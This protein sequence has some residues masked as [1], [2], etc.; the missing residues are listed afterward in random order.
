MTDT[1]FDLQRFAVTNAVL[2]GGQSSFTWQDGETFGAGA[3]TAVGTSSNPA[4]LDAKGGFS[5]AGTSTAV[6]LSGEKNYSF[7]LDGKADW[8]LKLGNDGVAQ[9]TSSDGTL[10]LGDLDD[11]AAVLN[12]NGTFEETVS[13]NSAYIKTAA[14]TKVTLNTRSNGLV[15]QFGKDVS[16]IDVVVYDNALGKSATAEFAKGAS[17]ID[18]GVSKDDLAQGFGF[19]K[20]VTVG[21]NVLNEIV[22]S[23]DKNNTVTVAGGDV[24]KVKKGE[25]TPTIFYSTVNKAVDVVNNIKGATLESA[26]GVTSPVAVA[27]V[28]WNSIT[29]GV[30]SIAFDSVGAA[31]VDNT[32]AITVQGQDGAVATVKNL[33][34]ATV[35]GIKVT[36]AE[37]GSVGFTLETLTGGGVSAIDVSKALGT[38]ITVAKD[39]AFNVTAG[40]SEY[41]IATDANSVTFNATASEVQ[42]N[43]AKEQAYTVSGNA[44][45]I[46]AEDAKNVSING[47][48]ISLGTAEGVVAGSDDDHEGITSITGLA[49]G[50]AVSVANDSD[51][52]TATFN[53]VEGADAVTFEVNGTS[54][55]AAGIDGQQVNIAV[56]GTGKEVTITGMGTT[57]SVT[58]SGGDGI[59][60]HFKDA[61]SSNRVAPSSGDSIY[62][63]LSN[64]AVIDAMD[65]DTYK[66]LME[67]DKGKWDNAA[68]IGNQTESNPPVDTVVSNLS[69]VFAQFY[70][71]N[72][73][74][75]GQA[76]MAGFVNEN[77]TTF[78]TSSVSGGVNFSGR[79][80]S[81][82]SAEGHVTLS[83]G[84]NVSRATP[85]NIQQNESDV[86]V[87]VVVDL[88]NETVPAT[89]A[90]GTL[91]DNVS[92][93]V[94]ASHKIYLSNAGGFAY[95]GDLATGQ[96]QVFAGTTGAQIRHD[97]STRATI[98][99]G[100]G[101]DTIWAGKNDIVAG[102]LG[103]DQFYD[104]ADYTITDY[105]FAQGD[106]LIATRFNSVSDITRDNIVSSGNTVSFGES[107][108]SFTLGNDQNASLAM[109]VAVMD[110]EAN[111]VGSRAVILAGANGGSVDASAITSGALIIADEN[112]NGKS[113]DAIVGTAGNDDI[114]VS[115]NDLVD[116][117]AGNDY[118]TIS[119]VSAAE[120][121]GGAKV[122]LG[123]GKDTVAGW[124]FGFDT[125]AGATE[126][127]VD[128]DYRGLFEN[129]RLMVSTASG[130]M[131]FDDT[132]ATYNHGQADVL[133]NGKKYMAI[134]TTDS[135]NTNS[136]TYGIVNSNDGLADAYVA[137]REGMLIIDSGVTQNLGT[138][139][140]GGVSYQNITSLVLANNNKA[141]V[142]GSD[143]RETLILG[144]DASVGASKEVFLG[145]GNDVIIATSDD[146][147][148][149]GND[150]F[151]GA[152]DGRDSIMGFNHY[153]GAEFDPDRKYADTLHIEKYGG[154]YTGT[155]ESGRSRIE[156][157]T[158]G[159]NRVFL[160][161]AN[162]INVNNVYQIQVGAFATKG[163][164]IGNSNTSNVFALDANVDYYVGSSAENAQDTLT[165]SNIYDNVNVWLDGSNGTDHTSADE[166][167]FRGITV[168]DATA[169]TNTNVSLAGAGGNDT[170][171]AGGEGTYNYLWGG[172]GDN[173]LYGS[174]NSK[175]DY[176]FYVRN[177]GAYLQTVDDTV[178]G[179]H[180]EIYNYDF[181]N[182]DVIWLGDTTLD[183][184]KSTDIGDTSVTIEFNNGGSLTVNSTDN[185]RVRLNEGAE[186]YIA[187]RDSKTWSHE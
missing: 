131:L 158:E 41:G 143:A 69:E 110:T 103:A 43:V 101:V 3:S 123:V 22:I 21:A 23:S 96:N 118:I 37:E 44:D 115:A 176:F 68:S 180:D 133:I 64:D 125:N 9:V 146:S 74:E 90:I 172:S 81:V 62:V 149:A 11:A 178:T 137:E 85:V 51:G 163:A 50:K 1:F 157:V 116:G 185:V 132:A 80:G 65:T 168:I 77:S 153:L 75:A 169:E 99:G 145:G 46:F 2:V 38:E 121:D 100:A 162:G 13:G 59:V 63:T 25:S 141:L 152:D 88:S 24:W 93:D 177:A 164:K 31:T 165:V 30:S 166:H 130:S 113:G 106:A 155:D 159:D 136:A 122:V 10:A 18:I 84:S 102:G 79:N 33:T 184:I 39:A 95:L 134:R 83:A 19:E 91:A 179:G 17:N 26:D 156:F 147:V 119:G 72:T 175:Q 28:I 167:Y 20:A 86:A 15:E 127:L 12:V 92:T 34:D 5:T 82:L 97:G 160:Y 138:I 128:G 182:N 78:E 150:L 187:D 49:V 27:G 54:I 32:A 173:V 48:N 73:S 89:V 104:S 140:M 52:F 6:Y 16:D 171:Y 40:K 108:H 36:A 124:T 7:S 57:D 42:V 148:R 56:D 154:I 94:T 120:N 53:S 76:S 58:V 161:E 107:R 181:E 60:Y 87:D 183:D 47:A 98:N 151:F 70:N 61:T 8:D 114:Y 142:L 144:G 45:Y 66:K 139:Q 67:N 117:G 4:Y 174:E 135:N 111:I 105:S 55:T 29:G 129:D 170:L 126:L 112:R 14:D 109:N 186:C 71:L 35:N